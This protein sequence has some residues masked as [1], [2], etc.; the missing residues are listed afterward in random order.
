ME[1]I[2]RT[3]KKMKCNQPNCWTSDA[4]YTA[5]PLNVVQPVSCK[6][7]PRQP[8]DG[9]DGETVPSPAGVWLFSAAGG[10]S[11]DDSR[12]RA[13]TACSVFRP[14]TSQRRALA[15]PADRWK[16]FLDDTVSTARLKIGWLGTRLRIDE[17]KS[18]ESVL[19]AM[20]KAYDACAD[21]GQL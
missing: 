18:S 9:D 2:V 15:A 16:W 19:C 14:P 21:M 13:S 5:W 1:K 3:Q 4:V 8:V 17:G 7:P 20:L 12:W 10:D 11:A 6:I